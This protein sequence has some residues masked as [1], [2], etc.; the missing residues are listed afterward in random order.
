M[1]KYKILYWYEIPI[2]VRATDKNGRINKQ[3]ADRFQASIDSA[4]MALG[5][6]GSEEYTDG[7][8]WGE[9]LDQPGTAADV[10][11]TIVSEL[12]KK[13]QRIDWRAVAAK[14]ESK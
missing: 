14:L 2:Q 10:A 13:Y 3:L 1:A 11:D 4:A 5:L 9:E 12:E 6:A 7:F 8:K